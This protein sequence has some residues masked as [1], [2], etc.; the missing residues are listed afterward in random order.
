M[1]GEP[2]FEHVSEDKISIIST[3][4]ITAEK[5]RNTSSDMIPSI[6]AYNNCRIRLHK[7][8][9]FFKQTYNLV[10][11]FAILPFYISL[12]TNNSSSQFSF[13]RILRL[14]R[15]FR[16]FKLGK[17]SE[18]ALLYAQVF[19]KSAEVLYLL[20]FFSLMISVVMG[21]LIYYFEKGEWQAHGCFEYNH[22]SAFDLIGSFSN[23]AS[24][25][26]NM[27]RGCFMR[28][29]IIPGGNEESPFYSIPQSIWWVVSTIT[30]V[31]YG[32]IYPTSFGGKIIALITMHIGLLGLALPI[33][34]ISANFREVFNTRQKYK[35]QQIMYDKIQNIDGLQLAEKMQMNLENIIRE[36]QL[37]QS[38]ITFYNP[39]HTKRN[40]WMPLSPGND[41]RRKLRN[42]FKRSASLKLKKGESVRNKHT[43]DAQNIDVY[44]LLQMRR[45]LVVMADEIKD[46]LRRENIPPLNNATSIEKN[47]KDIGIDVDCSENM[48]ECQMQCSQNDNDLSNNI[49]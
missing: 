28:N 48:D 3:I 40:E 11:F 15:V 17:Y 25:S 10:D 19:K 13:L 26:L 42:S 34:I 1:L 4:D 20:L 37:L 12:I 38:S 7:T 16:V 31:G 44:Q 33:T 6:S 29:K 27:T 18:A 36:C 22:G 24:L 23:H 30:T 2:Q 8:W 14:A 43:N 41:G 9:L 49:Q 46:A 47:D 35:S 5:D 39:L 21:S 32:D 45:S